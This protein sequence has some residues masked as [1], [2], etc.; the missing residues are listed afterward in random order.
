[1]LNIHLSNR[2]ESLL[3]LLAAQAREHRG[4]VFTPMTVIVP[5]AAIQ[6]AVTLHLAKRLGVCA[7]VD[8]S[9]PA[10]WIWRQIARMVPG[11]ASASPFDPDVL[12]WRVYRALG[13][14]EFVTAH[15]RL[16][17]YVGPA[18]D[19][20][21]FELAARCASLLEQYV[22]YRPDWMARWAAGDLAASEGDAPPL[23]DESWQAALWRRIASELA[24]G[25]EHPARAMLRALEAGCN[26]DLPASVH[27][28]GL[29]ALPPLYVGLLQQLGRWMDVH[30]YA[31]NP[32]RAYWFEV[33]SG[34]RLSWLASREQDE[35]FEQ[36]H[37]LLADWGRQTQAF[38]GS[39]INFDGD[40]VID[41][42]A[43]EPSAGLSLL[44]VLQ[45]SILELEEPATSSVALRASDRSV[46]VHS[47]HST[48]RELEVLQ[49]Y[50]LGLFAADKTLSPADVLVVTPDLKSIAPLIQ[51]VFGATPT[52]RRIPFTVT[53]LPERE[54]NP[55]SRLL[56]DLLAFVRSRCGVT[57]LLALLQHEAVA[58]RFGLDEAA[59]EDI[60]SWMHTAGMH[61][62]LDGRHRFELD[63]PASDK[64]SLD[65]G[66][67]RLF[68]GYALPE[69]TQTPFLD[70]LPAADAEGSASRALGALWAAIDTVKGLHEA[71]AQDRPG[72][73][74]C[75]LMLEALESLAT[76][77]RDDL[78]DLLQLRRSLHSLQD[79]MTEAAA[80]DPVPLAVVHTALQVLLEEASHGGVP[81]GT[82][83]FAPLGSLRGLP[84]KIVCA[85]GLNDGVVPSSGNPCEFDLMAQRPHAGDRQ[86]RADDRNVFLDLVL[87]AREQLYLSHVGRSV[88]DN[89]RI[90]P[91]IL[92]SELLEVLIGAVALDEPQARARLV[93]EH[94]LQPFSPVCFTAEDA[95]LRSFNQEYAQA[96]RLA[97]A[98]TPVPLGA[99]AEDDDDD[100]EAAWDPRAP[101][102]RQPLAPADEMW[103]EVP[104]A[105]LLEFF[106]NPSRFLLRRRMA[107][108]LPRAQELLDDDE[109]LL[110]AFDQRA[111]LADRL[112]PHAIAGLAPHDLKAL[113][114][115]GVEYPGGALGQRQI[116]AE[117]ALLQD[118]AARVRADTTN[119]AMPP[120]RIEIAL[121][122]DGV[123][124]RVHGDYADLR[125]EGLI[126]HRYDDTRTVDYLSGWLEHLLL[127]AG[128][129]PG[130]LPVTRWHSR[131]GSYRFDAVPDSQAVL[132]ALIRLYA[133]GLQRPLHFFPKS[134]WEY[135]FEDHDLG[136]AQAKWKV[137]TFR[138]YAE[139]A[140]PAY[141]LALRGVAD[142]LDEEFTECA[143][144]VFGPLRS[145]LRDPRL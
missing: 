55:Y 134:A 59:L 21:R 142:P 4:D 62:A 20:M 34:R 56:L 26:V 145:C 32:C 2:F 110:P 133:R 67:Q 69:G 63:L 31:L 117:L 82:V 72:G 93:V 57:D 49:D 124:W 80:V 129:P 102:F 18:D 143:K 13:D 76:P 11:I 114:L 109:P 84:Y 131:D 48:T 97:S 45:N 77:S 96:L 128:A 115:A 91:S 107:I 7:H 122:I 17:A 5:S 75:R 83:T 15:P 139:G 90:P 79:Q 25:D 88:R 70:R 50:L 43:F 22:T 100:E 28:V 36:G 40:V 3:E 137:T 64:H 37:R 60:Q 74:W 85:I 23:P 10:A 41:D 112:L 113:A 6:R 123:S 94:P 104:L 81:S 39:L 103:R 35:L 51:A 19:V 99:A 78:P 121:E 111:A 30:A 132:G 141:V 144:T 89:S 33:V 71:A 140:D 135:L 118:Y 8:F 136:K 66:L 101:F 130:V 27:V 9:F 16:S 126:R 119:P 42:G 92:V 52:A 61:W 106:R 87:A 95:R 12:A 138:P 127:C 108:E 120:H 44:A 54:S 105:R 116:E 98:A 14:A 47:C 73:E 24:L 38:L 46:E 29:P 65:D 53:G 125:S 86:R 68:L 58:R 1:M